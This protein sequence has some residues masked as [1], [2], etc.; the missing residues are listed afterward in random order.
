MLNQGLVLYKELIDHLV[1]MSSSCVDAACIAKGKIPGI[2]NEEKNAFL[3]R[4]SE[5]ERQ[6]LADIV[7]DTHQSVIYDVLDYLEWL[8]CCRKMTISIDG[9]LWQ[10]NSRK[11]GKCICTCNFLPKSA[12]WG[13]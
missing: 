8:Q 2:G 11:L 4:L 10:P 12:C 1:D 5:S 13:R 7:S 3:S 6:I 9:E